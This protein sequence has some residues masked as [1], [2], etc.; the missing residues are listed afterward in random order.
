MTAAASDRGVKLTSRSRPL[1]P[2][3]LQEYDYII[4][5]DPKNLRAMKVRLPCHHAVRPGRA[6]LC[7]APSPLLLF[8]ITCQGEFTYTRSTGMCEE[9]R[10]E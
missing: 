10:R 6:A 9:A 3:D 2:A 4:G 8:L 5:M 7:R 1:R